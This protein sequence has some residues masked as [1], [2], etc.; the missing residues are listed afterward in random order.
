MEPKENR[1]GDREAI[2]RELLAH[3]QILEDEEWRIIGWH[4]MHLQEIR[5]CV[6][7][8]LSDSQHYKILKSWLQNGV[9]VPAKLSSEGLVQYKG[10]EELNCG[11]LIE[12]IF[13][14]LWLAKEDT[15]CIVSYGEH[16]FNDIRE[17]V[18]GGA[19]YCIVYKRWDEVV[20]TILNRA[21]E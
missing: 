14:S 2:K 11:A 10:L 9:V 18:L 7:E 4:H 19:G 1:S 20:P 13:F 5:W 3:L 21:R 17:T 8:K 12:S 16:K 15:V 6:S